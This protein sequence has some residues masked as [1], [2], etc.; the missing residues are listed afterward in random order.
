MQ[1]VIEWS[2]G[3]KERRL[4]MKVGQARKNMGRF[5]SCALPIRLAN[6]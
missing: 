6:W 2:E 4:E 5:F 1:R 3:V